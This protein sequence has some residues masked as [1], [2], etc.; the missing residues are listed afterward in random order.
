MVFALIPRGQVDKQGEGGLME[1]LQGSLRG[2]EAT[3][4]KETRSDGG[5]QEEF[6]PK[7]DDLD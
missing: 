7:A 4:E 6:Q 2:A 5:A 3:R 1:R